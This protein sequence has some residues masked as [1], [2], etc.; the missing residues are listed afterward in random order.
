[1]VVGYSWIFDPV[2]IAARLTARLPLA[3]VV[4]SGIGGNKASDILARFD[5]D[6]GSQTP[7]DYVWIMVGTNDICQGVTPTEFS[8]N[9]FSIINKVQALGAI[10]IVFTPYTGCTDIPTRIDATRCYM[11]YVPYWQ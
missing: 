10:P 4:K 8:K 11:A 3:T 5:A 6:V 2:G 7:L 9:L 1:M